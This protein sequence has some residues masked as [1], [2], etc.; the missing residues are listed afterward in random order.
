MGFVQSLLRKHKQEK[1]SAANAAAD[2]ER[3]ELDYFVDAELEAR[4]LTPTEEAALAALYERESLDEITLASAVAAKRE[5][6]A[7]EAE[8]ADCVAARHEFRE[9]SLAH[10]AELAA[11]AI[12][13]LRRKRVD[14][15]FN[16]ELSHASQRSNKLQDAQARLKRA[17]PPGL[18]TELADSKAGLMGTR[19]ALTKLQAAFEVE[20]VLVSQLAQLVEP[21]PPL[22]HAAS[23]SEPN[24]ELQRQ[25]QLKLESY[26][27]AVASQQSRRDALEAMRTRLIMLGEDVERRETEHAELSRRLLKA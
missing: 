24:A 27:R 10:Q 17:L 3:I 14:E 23:R 13:D 16:G 2:A 9:L 15:V 26:R 8:V 11:R 6:I 4:K 19:Q 25:Y 20:D 12:E 21:L 18:Q 5:F 22:D 7:A 1:A